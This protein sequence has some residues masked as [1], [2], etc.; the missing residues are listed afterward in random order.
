MWRWLKRP[1]NQR[2]LAFVGCGL[3]TVAIASWTVYTHFHP[4]SSGKLN[5]SVQADRNSVAV[6]GE[7]KVGGDLDLGSPK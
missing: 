4:S 7:M 3:A 6:G 2:T 1:V 5:P